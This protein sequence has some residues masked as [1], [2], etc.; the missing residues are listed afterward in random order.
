LLNSEFTVFKQMTFY[1][2]L[3]QSPYLDSSTAGLIK[4]AER[5]YCEF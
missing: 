2:L 3:D 4:V 5:A 1:F